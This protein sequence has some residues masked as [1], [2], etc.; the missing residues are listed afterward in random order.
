MLWRT[1]IFYIKISP[2][3]ILEFYSEMNVGK[4]NRFALYPTTDL[5]QVWMEVWKSCSRP[6]CASPAWAFPM[7]ETHQPTSFLEKFFSSN[8]RGKKD[9]YFLNKCSSIHVILLSSFNINV[10]L[11]ALL[12]LSLLGHPLK[13]FFKK[14]VQGVT[15]CLIS[16]IKCLI[17][18]EYLISQL[19]V[20]KQEFCSGNIAC[21][22]GLF[23]GRC[24][25]KC[26]ITK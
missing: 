1:V 4:G 6:Y 14:P 26:L 19:N 15:Q 18:D 17:S 22:V 13:A 11:N 21:L 8:M 3:I 24:L 25:T 23:R 5:S 12:L 10:S 16:Q 9:N 2:L 20:I 7:L